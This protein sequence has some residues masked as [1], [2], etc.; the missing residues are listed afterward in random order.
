MIKIDQLHQGAQ[1]ILTT[2]IPFLEMK[3]YFFK[4][5]RT[6]LVHR[7]ILSVYETLQKKINNK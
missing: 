7:N 1:Q 5:I 2:P 6:L 4:I 3:L